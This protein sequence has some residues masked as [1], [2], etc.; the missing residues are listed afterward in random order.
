MPKGILPS[1]WEKPPVERKIRVKAGGME[2]NARL[3]HPDLRGRYTRLQAL[4]VHLA[5]RPMLPAEARKVMHRLLTW[6]GVA[7][8]E[9]ARASTPKH[10]EAVVRTALAQLTVKG[11]APR[12]VLLLGEG[13]L[14]DLA[15]QA[16]G[17]AGGVHS[18]ALLNP[19]A[20]SRTIS[21]YEKLRMRRIAVYA[22]S[23]LHNAVEQQ[24]ALEGIRRSFAGAS[25][26]MGTVFYPF[27]PGSRRD[28][29]YAYVA[30]GLAE[31]IKHALGLLPQRMANFRRAE[32]DIENVIDRDDRKTFARLG[33]RGR[34][35]RP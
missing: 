18:I 29:H 9:L 27:A 7:V 32:E 16:A 31:Q 13:R 24:Q 14:A 21:A 1:E 26:T 20:S 25:G 12:R 28:T 15:V 22:A 33:N 5:E 6:D 4:V 2:A 17:L 34:R 30:A 19:V 8:L 10:V 35:T 3:V 23:H 11:R